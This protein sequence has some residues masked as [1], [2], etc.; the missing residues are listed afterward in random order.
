MSFSS[1]NVTVS[2]GD[3]VV[4]V[5]L[6]TSTSVLVPFDVMVTALALPKGLRHASKQVQV[7][8]A[9]FAY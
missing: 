1:R 6:E 4:E 5:C 9:C 7:W 3:G 2:E 8:F